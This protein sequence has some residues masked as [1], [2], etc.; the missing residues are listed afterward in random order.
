MFTV[1][2]RVRIQP[3]PRV[4]V[5]GVVPEA[6]PVTMPEIE[7]IVAMVV[8]ALVHV[9]PPVALSTVVRLGHT[10]AVPAI[11]GGAGLTVI[12]YVAVQP[13]PSE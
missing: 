2:T 12:I 5:I 13:T 6:I 9:P 4:Y 3:V 11:G 7:P 1:T 8:V 10:D